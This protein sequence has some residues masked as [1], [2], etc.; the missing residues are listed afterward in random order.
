MSEWSDDVLANRP[1]L[2]RRPL[3]TVPLLRVA[4]LGTL[5]VA[6]SQRMRP[7]GDIVQAAPLA[8]RVAPLALSL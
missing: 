5:A 6:A 7:N 2:E 4:R 1:G 8:W 3:L